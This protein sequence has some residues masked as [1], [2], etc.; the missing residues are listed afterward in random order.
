MRLRPRRAQLNHSKP[1]TIQWKLYDIVGN[2]W[3][4][5]IL[6]AKRGE[7][8]GME[9]EVHAEDVRPARILV[10]EDEPIVRFLIADALRDAGLSVIE[11]ATADE[12]WHM[13][14]TGNIVNLVFT[15]HRMPGS[16]TGAELAAKIKARWPDIPVVM[17]SGDFDGSGFSERLFRKP[18][19]ID[20]V[21][22]ELVHKAQLH[23]GK[24]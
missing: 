23:Q 2:F 17:T 24:P 12:A 3:P 1:L 11:A 19:S 16:M 10:V 5:G 7:A 15:D 14:A 4:S 13:L 9:P 6:L 20:E 21:V 8:R 22:D 18:Y